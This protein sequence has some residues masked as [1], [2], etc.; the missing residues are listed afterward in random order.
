MLPNYTVI[1]PNSLLSQSKIINYF[2]PSKE[3][4][5]PV[6]VGV[7]YSSDLEHVERATLEVA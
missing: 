4:S 6:E 7:H 3:L 2:Y 1:M 5:V